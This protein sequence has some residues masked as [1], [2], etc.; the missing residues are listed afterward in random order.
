MKVQI[1]R[2]REPAHLPLHRRPTRKQLPGP[3]KGHRQGKYTVLRVS[4]LDIPSLE[5]GGGVKGGRRPALT[6]LGPRPASY[7]RGL[8]ARPWTEGMLRREQRE[9]MGLD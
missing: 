5:Q 8:T 6:R 1:G 2:Q 4:Q 3:A 7:Q 9:R